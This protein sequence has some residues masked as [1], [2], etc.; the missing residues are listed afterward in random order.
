MAIKGL[1]RGIPHSKNPD[2]KSYS[3][4]QEPGGGDEK[5]EPRVTWWIPSRWSDSALSTQTP[6]IRLI[7][8]TI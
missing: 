5:S 7:E 3:G 2:D 8:L 4:T 6:L 1:N